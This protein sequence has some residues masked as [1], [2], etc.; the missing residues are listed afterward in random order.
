M[1]TVLGWGLLLVHG[2]IAIYEVG[3]ERELD[4]SCDVY[5]GIYLLNA[6]CCR[7]WV[8]ITIANS[9]RVTPLRMVIVSIELVAV[10]M[11]LSLQHNL[12]NVNTGCVKDSA[13]NKVGPL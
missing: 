5:L 9:Q 2:D 12:A 1:L 13:R 10:N 3:V 8:H 7:W 6:T 4:G 11:A